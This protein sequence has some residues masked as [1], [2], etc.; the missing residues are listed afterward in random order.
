MRRWTLARVSIAFI[1]P[2]AVAL[3]VGSAGQTISPTTTAAPRDLGSLISDLSDSDPTVRASAS[4]R[5]ATLGASARSALTNAAR[6]GSAET[7]A[8]ASQ[9][10]LGLPWFTADDPETVKQAMANYGQLN[11]DERIQRVRALAELPSGSGQDM[12]IRILREEPSAAVRWAAVTMLRSERE[13]IKPPLQRLREMSRATDNP[14]ID[15]SL[16][17]E[18]PLLAVVGWSWREIDP[19]RCRE[20]LLRAVHLEEQEPTAVRGQLDF[21]FAWLVDRA[22]DEQRYADAVTLLR[23]QAGR[24]RFNDEGVP[25]PVGNLFALHAQHGPFEGLAQD[26]R[27]YR[28]YLTEPEMI[29]AA[30]RL[31]ERQGHSILA[32]TVEVIALLCGGTAT[33]RHAQVGGFLSNQ[34]WIEQA[35]RELRAAIWLSDGDAINAYFQLARLAAERDDELGVAR[36]L[37]AAVE[38]VGDQEM[39]RTTKFGDVLPW[40]R[41]DAWAEVHWHYLRAARAAGDVAAVQEHL[42]KLLDL[43]RLQNIMHKDPGLATDLVPA[44]QETGRNEEAKKCFDAAYRDLSDALAANPS[45]PEA[46]NNLAWLCARCGQRLD[47]AVKLADE[48]IVAS[49]A[50]AAYLDTAAEAHFR[51]GDITGAVRLESEALRLRPTDAFMKGQLARFQRA[52]TQPAP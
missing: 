4:S 29:Y 31:A 47:E 21:A 32:S 39:R 10:L 46:K 36:N 12:L 52:A 28:P 3:T 14:A 27:T 5:L 22:S 44:L 41:D 50:S 49:P 25:A 38:R 35:E 40:T 11:I 8:A 34:G 23:Q 19:Q 30:A 1:L 15:S 43:N 9:I 20:L 6:S 45:N 7:R 18:A 33:D 2:L 16:V 51:S 26:L 48:A 24:T 13:G 37:Q 42:Q 17:D